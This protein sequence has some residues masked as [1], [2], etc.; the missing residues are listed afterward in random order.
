[1]IIE[2]LN[3]ISWQIYNDK[4]Y[5][6]KEKIEKSYTFEGLGVEYWLNI[7]RIKD[8]DIIFNEIKKNHPELNTDNIKTHFNNFL[9]SLK[10]FNI[11]TTK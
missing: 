5:I 7:V 9:Q 4:V 10:K 6:I 2:L 11:I 8:Y 1:M 3:D